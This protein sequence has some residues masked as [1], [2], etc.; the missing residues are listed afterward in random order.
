MNLRY[1]KKYLVRSV[2][3]I[4]IFHVTALDKKDKAGQLLPAH[5]CC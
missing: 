1:K 3:R 4:I 5:I 2:Y